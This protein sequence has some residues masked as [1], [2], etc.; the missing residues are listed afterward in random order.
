MTTNDKGGRLFV[1]TLL[2][3]QSKARLNTGE[4]LYRYDGE[5]YAPEEIRGPAPECRISI[6]P[7]SPAKEDFFLKVLTATNSSV[8]RPLLARFDESD[9]VI[10]VGIGKDLIEFQKKRLGGRIEIKGAG[11]E[12]A[13]QV[14]AGSQE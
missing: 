3:R 2:P 11:R 8:E 1:Q 4:D 10:T 7:S 13:E 9:E 5:N 6:S 14:L 12:L